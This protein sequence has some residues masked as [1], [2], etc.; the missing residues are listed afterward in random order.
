MLEI[1]WE[2][3]KGD[4]GEVAVIKK[5]GRNGSCRTIRTA[6]TIIAALRFGD[7]ITL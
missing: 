5:W 4:F 2:E 7:P 1:F 6:G 3:N